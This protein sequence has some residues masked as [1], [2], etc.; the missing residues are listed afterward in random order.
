MQNIFLIE[1]NLIISHLYRTKFAS[2]GF[3]VEL[4][5]DGLK[6]VKL[7]A[8]ATPDLIVLDLMLPILSGVDVLKYIRSRPNLKAIPV[9]LLSEAYMSDLAQQAEIV[10]VQ[11]SV[12]KSACTPS[13]LLG[14]VNDILAG[15][16][17][18]IDPSLQLAVPSAPVKI[19][20]S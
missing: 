3:Q 13:V 19:L 10:G 6:A 8:T 2:E 17:C 15:R 20:Q 7:L 11:Q 4:A 12:L 16:P 5:E 1:D 18:H 9:V 14:I